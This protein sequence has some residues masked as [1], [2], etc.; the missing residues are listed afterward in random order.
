[1][2]TAL[3]S[4]SATGKRPATRTRAS[5]Q[6]PPLLLEPLED[7][8][9]LSGDVVLEWNQVLLNTIKANKVSPL[10]FTRDAAIVHAAIYDAVNDIDRSYTPLFADVKAPH[11]A[12]LEAAAAQAA[13]DTL[14]ALFPGQQALFDTTLAADLA[15]IPPGRATLGVGVGREV[16]QQIL[17]WR[18]TDGSTA[19]VP[20]VP[21]SGPGVWQPTPRP[22]PNPPPAELPG[23]PA[24]A[25]QWP[26][27]TPFCIPSGAAFRPAG[28][29]SLTS[30]EYAA[31]FDEVKS[32][33]ARD[34]TARTPQQTEIALFWA[35]GAGT[36]TI[37][38][39]WNQIAQGVAV[40]RGTTLVQNARLFALLNVA[41]ADAGIAVWD[42]KY[43]Y[44]FWRPVTAIRAA[45]APDSPD[46]SWTP[47]LV[48]PNHPSYVSA[49][50]GVASAAAA[51]LAGFFGTDAVSFVTGSEGVPGVTH[52]FPSFSAAA[53]EVGDS[54]VYAG[55]H[56]RF[57]ITAALTLGDQVGN[58]V[59]AHCLLPV[60]GSDDGDGDATFASGHWGT[61]THT[62]VP[63]TT[64]RGGTSPDPA[65]LSATR[66][67]SQ[68]PSLSSGETT[69]VRV[70]WPSLPQR[71]TSPAENSGGPI[72]SSSPTFPGSLSNPST[73]EDSTDAARLPGRTRGMPADLLDQVLAELDAGLSSDGWSNGLAFAQRK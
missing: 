56:W 52:A 28:P 42:A 16:A 65:L 57:D 14:A 38:G 12:S 73:G 72:L 47:L 67:P 51:S 22:N 59:F 11:G 35:D 4:R 44:N 20:Y 26:D 58:A 25:P 39:H 50:T 19:Q 33:G 10:F 66:V 43:T 29:P 18:S 32:L 1:M 68:R 54:R 60:S 53:Q 27:V 13:H 8:C 3:R 6:R 21:G 41:M 46:A 23:L 7:R 37:G 34:S 5:R 55:I 71:A 64:P 63:G 2:F 45:A 70:A 62:A 61:G 49:H 17:T 15:G 48:T 30:A 31:A 40:Q 36:V 9:L 69:A 24:A